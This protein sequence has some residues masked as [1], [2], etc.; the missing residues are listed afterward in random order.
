ML[1][2]VMQ[3]LTILKFGIVLTQNYNLKILSL[4][5]KVS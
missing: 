2:K 3:V 4:Q 1:L 5:V